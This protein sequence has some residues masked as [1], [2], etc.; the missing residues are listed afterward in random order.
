MY[1]PQRGSPSVGKCL[2]PQPARVSTLSLS[3]P[4]LNGAAS[5]FLAPPVESRLSCA[6][7]GC[8][9]FGGPRLTTSSISVAPHP[10]APELQFMLVVSSLSWTLAGAGMAINT[11][12]CAF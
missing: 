9:M 8:L 11:Q 2:W 6:R 12:G 4:A 5:L 3:G 1:D 7:L 10:P